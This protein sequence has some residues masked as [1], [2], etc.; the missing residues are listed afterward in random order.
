MFAA[1]VL[2]AC[3]APTQFDPGTYG[4]VSVA[5]GPSL[6]EGNEPWRSDQL[7]YLQRELS[8]LN[9]LGPS[10]TQ[11]DEGSADVVVRPF[12]S[13]QGCTKGAGRYVPGSD[14]VEVD[15]A[16]AGGYDALARAAGHELMHWLTDHKYHWVGHLCAHTTDATNCS[17]L[18]TCQDCLLSP[19]LL[20]M[21]DGAGLDEAWAP[22][23]DPTPAAEDLQLVASCQAAGSCS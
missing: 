13:G 16:C 19:G 3:E 20:Q 23:A 14:Y 2:C 11:T 10:W 8:A 12:D 15:P 1:L 4:T 7:P 21:D 22:Y 18:V 9:G 17:R 6:D 5:F